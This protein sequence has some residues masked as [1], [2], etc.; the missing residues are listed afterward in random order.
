M[1]Y[2]TAIYNIVRAIHY[3]TNIKLA[4]YAVWHYTCGDKYWNGTPIKC[5]LSWLGSMQVNSVDV[6]NA[7]TTTANHPPAN[8]E[9]QSEYKTGK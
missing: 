8:N 4:L 5:Q 2:D 3:F 6:T 9:N 1:I 7:V